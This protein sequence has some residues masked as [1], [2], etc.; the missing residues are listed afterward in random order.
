MF[1]NLCVSV[2]AERGR[3]SNS[4]YLAGGLPDGFFFRPW[5]DNQL[6]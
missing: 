3:H 5:L 1:N 4:E 2:A 6:A